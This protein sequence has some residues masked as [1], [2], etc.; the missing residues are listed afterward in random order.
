M[1]TAKSQSLSLLL[2]VIGILSGCGFHLQG[3]GQYQIDPTFATLRVA[4]AGNQLQNDP[5][6]VA[7]KNALRTQ[8]NIKVVD[9]GDAP[10]LLLF[11]EKTDNQVLSMSS[12][13]K[14]DQYQLIYQVSFQL[15]GKDN[16]PLSKPQTVRAQREYTFDRL[17]VL[18]MEKESAD[19]QG[20]LQRDA[21]Q[22]L[23]RRLA[24][25]VPVNQRA[26][27]H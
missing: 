7:M 4:V 13:G 5:L 8:T 18:A 22:Q 2:L 9:T 27:Q 24:H 11:G 26:D 3:T 14:A 25:I 19:L 20:E 21:V 23:L 15:M 10:V 12:T 6:L 1:K 17:N 16:Q